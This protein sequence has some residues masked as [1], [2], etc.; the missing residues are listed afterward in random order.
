M[1][2]GASFVHLHLHSQY[3]LLDGAVRLKDLIPR[4][5]ELG[6]S[7][8]AVTDHGNM[9][10][11]FDFYKQAIAAGVKPI[12]GCETYVAPG[13]RDDKSRRGAYHLILLARNAEGYRNLKYLVSMG[14]VEGFYYNPRI[15]KALLAERSAG[16]IGASACLGGEVAQ[17][18]VRGGYASAKE[19]A[20]A[21]RA[22]FEP[23]AFFLEVQ[24]NGYDGQAEY[25]EA[26]RRIGQELDIPLLA[27]NDVHYLTADDAKAHQVLMAIGKGVTLDDPKAD[28]HYTD[29]LYLR[30][31]DEMQKALGRF[32]DALENTIRV[33]GMCESVTPAGPLDLPAFQVP[34]GTTLEEYLRRTA[35][36]MLNR[37][38]AELERI[39]RTVDTN[40]YRK[41]LDHELGVICEMHYAGYF[42]IVQDFIRYAREQGIPVGPGR[43]SGAG[44]LVAFALKITNLDPIP[45][46]LLFERFLN[47]ERKSMPDFDVDFC[48][49][50]REQV[51]EYVAE[52]YGAANVGQI[53]TFHQ[54]RSRSVVRDVGRVMGMQYGDVDKIAKLVPEGP[55][56]SLAEAL[57]GEEK[58][59]Q[60]RRADP[61]VDELLAYA[62]RLENLN[63]HAGM[64][65]AGVVIG[66]KPLWEYVP[67]FT[68]G[69]RETT[70]Q[71]VS[72]F[73]MNFVE[74]CGLVK[75]D[76]LGLKTLTVIR[77][78][79]DLVNKRR[80]EGERLDID[81]LPLDDQKVYDLISSGNT[82]G[83]FQ[84]ESRGFQELLRRLKP[85]CF[86]DIVAAV[87]L[88]RPG[89]LEGGM[90]EQFVE[91][92]HGRREIAYPHPKLGKILKETYGVI[93]YQEQVMQAAQILAGYSLGAADIMR[94]AMGKKKAD[95]MA[96]ERI[97]F[98]GGCGENGI[99]GPLANEIF[100]LIDKFA[101]YGFNK[102]HSAAYA[103]ITY[104]TAWL[105][106]N[107]PV[108]FEAA[109]LTCD[110]ENTDKIAEYIRLGRG[111]G[112]RVLPPDINRS[113]VDFSV[114]YEADEPGAGGILFG[115]GAIKGVGDAALR[116]I[117]EA[118]ADGAFTD[119]FD[120][121][122]RV[123]LAKVNKAVM[124]GLVRSGAFDGCE[125]SRGVNRGQIFGALER[126]VER[127]KSAQRDREVG[128]ISL[129]GALAAPSPAAG[130]AQEEASLYADLR[131]WT[132][133]ELLAYEKTSVG[134]FMSGHP[135][136][137]YEAE[138][139]RLTGST[140][141]SV[142]ACGD[143]DEITIAGIMMDFSERK[144]KAGKRLGLGAIE[145]LH[146]RVNVIV[147]SQ[148]LDELG[149][150]L[151]SEEPLFIKGT[152]LVDEREEGEEKKIRVAEAMPLADVRAKRTKEVHL[153]IDGAAFDAR[154][155]DD[156]K[157]VLEKN[158]G[159]CDAFLEVAIAGRS[160]TTI[161]LPEQFRL[162]PT[163]EL[164]NG[165]TGFP[166]VL[167]VEFR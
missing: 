70:T 116:S 69:D 63:R 65:A 10:G 105:K 115:L 35:H 16:L 67:V 55:K 42:L 155:L 120:F 57:G 78:A 144:T 136:E 132:E 141:T 9:F 114:H 137:R 111:M 85:D 23:G 131:P 68:G 164:L 43:G 38:F 15:D 30:S 145:D 142:A 8:V 64:H 103:L 50:R 98:V 89:P 147:F 86:E 46:N 165:L 39:G 151:R 1:S 73:D 4:V 20:A 100:D 52:K 108:E 44:S 167:D 6:M 127:G 134:F 140:T 48:K 128:Q 166:G 45:L 101:G 118:R 84:L 19:A 87:A 41:R 58:L 161:T 150:V 76:F 62:E 34:E 18:F 77:T 56:V 158:P 71:L 123:D 40:Q 92:K 135:M 26:L 133:R 28:F 104:Q 33:A 27:T 83:V 59:K 3:S 82:W 138:A 14:Y 60:A 148:Q 129:F 17:A 36:E 125:G 130:A 124:E 139:A 22:I 11:A 90:V 25:N 7:A 160:R 126:A 94:R 21:Y 112:T 119:V 79:V 91:C 96:K 121:A 72:Q 113:D 162:A 143:R 122:M 31:A 29:E 13:K 12:L 106:A 97:K 66:N 163:D 47:P 102:S 37:R 146:G 159:R 88:Y 93:V 74:D 54:L 80:G 152:V 2:E 117:L 149:E 32:P 95:V 24:S 156:L 75:F 99:E 53:A 107:H 61:K 5:R 154:A 153:H 81:E 157:G 110:R 51:I 49:D 109:L